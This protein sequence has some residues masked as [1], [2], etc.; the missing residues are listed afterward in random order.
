[1]SLFAV[2]FVCWG[3]VCW[4]FILLF[5]LFCR[6]RRLCFSVFF[7]RR[8]SAHL[9]SL[10][11]TPANQQQKNK[12]KNKTA[13]YQ[14]NFPD[15]GNLAPPVIAASDVSFSYAG[16]G[17]GGPKIFSNLD[18][19]VDLDT[20]VAVVGPN[21]IGKSTL[22]GLI[23]GALEPTEGFVSRNPGV[24]VA[25]FSQHHVDGLDLALTPVEVMCR[26]YAPALKEQEA[27]AHLG[28]FGVGGTLALQALYTLS[29]GQKSR[30]ALAKLTYSKPHVLLLDEVRFLFVSF[31]FVFRSLSR[32]VFLRRPKRQKYDTALIKNKRFLFLFP[33]QNQTMRH[34]HDPDHQTPTQP[35]HTE[36]KHNPNHK[37]PK[38]QPTNHLDMESIDALVTGLAGFPGGVVVVSH[39]AHFLSAA[40]DAFWC[41]E[42]GEERTVKPFDGTFAEYR[43][44][45]QKMRARAAVAAM[46][47]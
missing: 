43:A 41:V 31:C 18:L 35:K 21:G 2:V 12:T 33:P 34:K 10:L 6:E 24:R 25:V 3:F 14:F 44:R 37:T 16:K 17:K 4:G 40:V 28:A 7:R 19:S 27:R 32:S 42:G 36:P 8:A 46:A 30:V 39:D 38:K 13:E 45:V 23:S 47:K 15:P 26:A 29:G 11:L 20:R 9:L 1:V 22:L 5:V